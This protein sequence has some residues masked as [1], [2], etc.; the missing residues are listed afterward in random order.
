MDETMRDVQAAINAAARAGRVAVL[1]YCWG[2]SL[3][4]LAAGRLDGVECAVACSDAQ[5]ASNLDCRPRVPVQMHFA[6]HDNYIM[7]ED[8]ARIRHALP[9]VPIYEYP[10]TEHGFN[11]NDRQF[12]NSK[13]SALARR[14][15]LAF[16]DLHVAE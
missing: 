15:A 10:G 5:I 9:G 14:R 4:N 6:G 1:G 11:C 7:D 13:A 3:A 12:Y 8:I 2:G 16:M